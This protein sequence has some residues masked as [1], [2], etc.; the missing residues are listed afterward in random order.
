MKDR[1]T[2]NGIEETPMEAYNGEIVGAQ[3]CCLQ[4]HHVTLA[5]LFLAFVCG[6]VLLVGFFN[7]DASVARVPAIAIGSLS[8]VLI[9]ITS[10]FAIKMRHLRDLQKY[11]FT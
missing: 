10:F 9:S 2:S 7:R 3:G 4:I 6:T 8:I 1:T 11:S 5:C